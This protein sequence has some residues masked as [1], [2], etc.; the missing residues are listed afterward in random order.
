MAP[1]SDTSKEMALGV[2]CKVGGFNIGD[3]PFVNNTWGDMS[4]RYKIA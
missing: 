1:D 3:I 4:R 2:A